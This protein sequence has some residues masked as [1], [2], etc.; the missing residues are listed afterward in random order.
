MRRGLNQPNQMAA[1]TF[2]NLLHD[3]KKKENLAPVYLLMGEEGY[4]IDTLVE[5]FENFLVEEEDKDFDLNIFYG[6]DGDLEGIVATAQQFPVMSE[7]KLVILKE[8][9]TMYQAKTQLD[10]LALYLKHPNLTTVFVIAY[11][12]EKLPATSKFVKGFSG[13]QNVIFR[14]DPVKEWQ[15]AQYVKEYADS[16][17]IKAED[18]AVALLCEY[19]GTPLSKL[20][21]EI[22]KLASIK[23]NERRITS[24]DVETY[25]GVSKDYNIFEF[26]KALGTKDYVQAMKIL[27]Y[28]QKNPKPNPTVKITGAVFNYFQ[29]IAIAHF[30]PDKSDKGLSDALGLKNAPALRELKGAMGMYNPAQAIKCIHFIRDF[31]CQSKGI[32]SYQNEYDLL[33]DLIFKLITIR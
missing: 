19:I 3:I 16:I 22:D 14:S 1:P 27:K 15:L 6:N 25:I 9:Q 17:N 2:R 20:F 30:L 4:Y 13:T 28:F 10:K 5:A 7:R 12:G 8:A 29:R 31:D 24:K 18:K 11:K 32:G 23:K 21:G 33:K 26:T